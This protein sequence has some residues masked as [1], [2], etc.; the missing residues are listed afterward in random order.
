MFGV[1]SVYGNIAG[2]P[3]LAHPYYVDGAD[4]PVSIPYGR[5]NLPEGSRLV[6]KLDP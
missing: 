6:R 3:V 4:H 5:Q 1:T 2:G